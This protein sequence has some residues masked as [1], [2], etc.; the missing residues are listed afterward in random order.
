MIGYADVFY[1]ALS[2][3][4]VRE[5]LGGPAALVS[6]RRSVVGLRLGERLIPTDSRGHF[7][8]NFRGPEGSFPRVSAVAVLQGEVAAGTFTDRFVLVGATAVG[9]GDLVATP[10]S[11]ACPGVEIHATA[12]DNML[13]GD[14]MEF[15][16]A[17]NLGYTFMT[18]LLAGLALAAL[19]AWMR[20]IP[21]TAIAILLLVGMVVGNYRFLFLNHRIVG[22]TFPLFSLFLVLAAITL[23]RGAKNH[24]PMGSGATGAETP[25]SAGGGRGTTGHEEKTPS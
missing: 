1:P 5:G 16:A 13:A 24:L 12:V 9:I 2:F 18:V 15:D 21:G 17:A 4:M 8:L 14:C 11:A 3:E 23:Y 22:L 6:S 25:P 7:Y 10:M 20:P 19:L